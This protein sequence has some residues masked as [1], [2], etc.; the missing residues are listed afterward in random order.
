M[1]VGY[2]FTRLVV[3]IAGND[4]YGLLFPLD[5][6]IAVCLLLIILLDW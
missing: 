1:F 5:C 4:L 2:C 6:T 3:G